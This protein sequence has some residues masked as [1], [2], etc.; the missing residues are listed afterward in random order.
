MAK[1]SA[2]EKVKCEIWNEHK[3]NC[4]YFSSHAGLA[5]RSHIVGLQIWRF[6]GSEFIPNHK[7]CLQGKDRNFGKLMGGLSGIWLV[8][9]R[10]SWLVGGLVGL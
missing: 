3:N 4:T 9:E 8:C 10:T 2:M 1:N 6:L 5:K 7:K